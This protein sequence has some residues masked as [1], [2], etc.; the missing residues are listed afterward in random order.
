MRHPRHTG[1]LA[2][3]E[4]PIDPT[5][6]MSALP[7]STE[8]A[9]QNVTPVRTRSAVLT[10]EYLGCRITVRGEWAPDTFV[11]GT[12][13]TCPI[14]KAAVAAFESLGT[15]DISSDLIEAADPTHIFEWAKCEIDFLLEQPF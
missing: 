6:G 12:Y 8:R 3:A 9:L 4:A 14:S 13:E 11:R 5:E 7:A 1:A 15:A 10:I 2:C